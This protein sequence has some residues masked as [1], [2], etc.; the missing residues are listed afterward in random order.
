MDKAIKDLSRSKIKLAAKKVNNT[1]ELIS[2][3]AKTVEKVEADVKV[4]EKETEDILK[5]TLILDGLG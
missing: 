1:K 5:R 3:A 2:A 4:M